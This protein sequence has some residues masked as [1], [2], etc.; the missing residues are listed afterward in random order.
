MQNVSGA[1]SWSVKHKSYR[2]RGHVRVSNVHE[3]QDGVSN[4]VMP[5]CTFTPCAAQRMNCRRV[6]HGTSGTRAKDRIV[7]LVRSDVETHISQEVGHG[8][9]RTE[10]WVQHRQPIM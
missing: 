9:A 7:Q 10:R 6:E 8:H 3:R 2:F 4:H 1:R 5:S